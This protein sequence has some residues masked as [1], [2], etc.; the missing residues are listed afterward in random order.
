[1]N[2]NGPI[3]KL[4]TDEVLPVLRTIQAVNNATQRERDGTGCT[5][6]VCQTERNQKLI[7]RTCLKSKYL[8]KSKILHYMQHFLHIGH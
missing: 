4:L 1:M 2:K 6:C 8:N 7:G 5:K 3:S